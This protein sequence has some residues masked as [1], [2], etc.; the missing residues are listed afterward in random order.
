MEELPGQPAPGE[1]LGMSRSGLLEPMATREG[2]QGGEVRA[3]EQLP[4]LPQP[5]PPPT[6]SPAP[7]RRGGKA[8]PA[9]S[10]GPAAASL[11][12][13]QPPGG[14]LLPV[15]PSPGHESKAQAEIHGPTGAPS[16]P[17]KKIHRPDGTII[18]P[19][20]G[21]IIEPAETTARH[22]FQ[23]SRTTLGAAS[24]LSAFTQA[25]SIP[26]MPDGVDLST[27]GIE[28]AWLWFQEMD[29]DN[30]GE[31]DMREVAALTARLGMR[32]GKRAVKR[33]FREMNVDGKGGVTFVD[34]VKW[35]NTQQAIARRDMRRVIKELFEE[36]DDDRSGIL[37]KGEFAKLVDNANSNLGLPALFSGGP[38][39]P[40]SDNKDRFNLEE[41]WH[42]IRKV[43]FAEG[44]K[45]GVN[46][47]GFEAWWKAKSGAT[48]PDI[49]VLPEFMVLKIN[50]RVRQQAAWKKSMPQG[51]L[52]PGEKRQSANWSVLAAKLRTLV[53]MQRQWGDLHEIYETRAES[54]FEQ[55]PLPPYVRDPDSE[56]SAAWD[57]TSVVLLLYVAIVI[58]LRAC[59]DMDVELWSGMFWWDV[60]V[61]VFFICDVGL[62][63]R[64]SFFDKNG[65]REERPRKMAIQYM[66]GW[67]VIDLVSCLPFGYVGYFQPDDTGDGRG[68]DL[69][70]LKAFRLI[71][72]TKLLRLARIKKILTKYGSDVNFQ[73]YLSI[74]FTLFA[75]LFLMHMLACFFFLIGVENETL[76]NGVAV[77]GW[78]NANELWQSFHANG[79]QIGGVSPK[80]STGHKYAA[81]LYFVLNALENGQ[82]LAEHCYGIFAELIRDMILGLVASLMT[83]IS[84]SMASSDNEN[85]LRLKR[86]KLWLHQKKMPTGF[87]QRMMS[88][89]NEVWTNQS[90]VDLPGMMDSMPPA[91]RSTLAE[92][93]YGRFLA[94]VPLFKGLSPEVIAALCLR[95][96]PMV[97]MK[98]QLITKQGESGKE[99]YMV[100]SGEVEVLE[101]G[102][103]LGFLSE[104]AFFGESP[105]LGFGEAGTETRRRTVMAVT[106]TELCYVTRDSI[107]EICNE[108]SELRA[109]LARF[110]NA[111]KPMNAKRLKQA[112]LTRTDLSMFS[113]DCEFSS[114]RFPLFLA[115]F[116]CC[117]VQICPIYFVYWKAIQC[118]QIGRSSPRLRKSEMQK[119]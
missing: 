40:D 33:A 39:D 46:F 17:M 3:G 38:N 116:L 83:T 97:G 52:A 26:K 71:R 48:E 117:T 65:F 79:T 91:M 66:K 58:P 20:T 103:R 105:I 113:S 119:V 100:M 56:F 21:R 67:F 9:G 85:S 24:A 45:L 16:N 75:I 35:W 13:W 41:A 107:E 94:T 7:R 77:D 104:G 5:K 43:P 28:T 8:D 111:A 115:T 82:T 36:A 25:D 110:A 1:S 10:S 12:M 106:E 99:M 44:T 4:P 22:R 11:R 57:L 64:T 89:F 61:D 73:Q 80:I 92:Y 6:G 90:S 84:M 98:N 54:L 96:R 108:Y 76:G 62:N 23:R 50:D 95:V 78:V 60:I 93:L 27:P 15:S 14:A 118:L 51:P 29:T 69:K 42:E 49:P 112:G 30:S 47:A 101:D 59:F 34:F 87:Q 63:F 32:V 74:G 114:P 102:K 2:K 31:M 86:L 70:A 19:I 81:S 18:S 68:Q 37:E 88:H 72:M 109:R 53:G 55:A